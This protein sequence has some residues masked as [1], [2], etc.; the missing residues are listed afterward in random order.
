M[1]LSC[2]ATPIDV[3]SSN[4][5]SSPSGVRIQS[6]TCDLLPIIKGAKLKIFPPPPNLEIIITQKINLIENAYGGGTTDGSLC[7][8]PTLTI[9]NEKDFNY[10]F[11]GFVKN[12][13]TKWANL[14]YSEESLFGLCVACYN[15]LH[16]LL[17]KIKS[18]EKSIISNHEV[19][20]K[21]I[22]VLKQYPKP[23][24][25]ASMSQSQ[26]T[27]SQN[28]DS[29]S[30]SKNITINVTNVTTLSVE[31][32]INENNVSSIFTSIKKLKDKYNSVNSKLSTYTNTQQ[33]A[34]NVWNS[35]K[36]LKPQDGYLKSGNN[37]I[38]CKIQGDYQKM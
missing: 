28:S 16:E 32:G 19:F 12:C 17:K 5:Y 20:E 18:L 3:E 11:T 8:N 37:T 27:Q 31:G 26:T 24:I 34:T 33:K 13:S 7:G 14:V 1:L 6:G 35:Y 36:S 23:T 25:N 30:D 2:G 9:K 38:L 29:D 15:H 10:F 21:N 4:K 22:K